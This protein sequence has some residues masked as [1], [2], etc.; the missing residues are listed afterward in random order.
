MKKKLPLLTVFILLVLALII[1]FVF[2]IKFDKGITVASYG[3]SEKEMEVFADLCKRQFNEKQKLK[4]IRL[5]S[6]KPLYDE[7]KENPEIDILFSENGLALERAKP[8]LEKF[9]VAL[10]EKLPSVF[11]GVGNWRKILDNAEESELENSY[12]YVYP[13]SY[14][15]LELVVKKTFYPL[16]SR[17]Q[18]N[19]RSKIEELL[20]LAKNKFNYPLAFAA[21]DDE[22]LALMVSSLL[23]EINVDYTDEKFSA[24]QEEIDFHKNLPAPLQQVLDILIS[25]K[26]AGFLHSQWYDLVDTDVQNFLEFNQSPMAI[27]TVEKHIKGDRNFMEEYA[28]QNM[29]L[30]ETLAG[31]NIPARLISIGLVQKKRKDETKE[32]LAKLLSFFQ[33]LEAQTEIIKKLDLIAVEYSANTSVACSKAAGWVYSSNSIT[34]TIDK[35]LFETDKDRKKFFKEVRSY[36]FQDGIGY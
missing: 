35:M 33:S 5:S 14:N 30:A 19:E 1:I 31:S 24:L 34:P 27:M 25:W 12:L 13:L 9:D 26:K 21:A 10:F 18:L 29:L 8:L 4:F 32:A 11:S 20:K 3:L 2:V 22:T 16:A 15:I 28:Q 36:I 7:L 6:E 23:T 17:I